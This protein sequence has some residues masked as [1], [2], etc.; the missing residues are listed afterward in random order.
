[1]ESWSDDELLGEVRSVPDAFAVFYRRYERVVFRYFMG[2]VG[3]PELAADLAA[4]TFA[5]A[6]LS[7]GRYRRRDGSASAWLFGIAR[8][9]LLRSVERKRVEDRARRKLGWPSLVLDDDLLERISQAGADGRAEAM[10]AR[11][12][13][14]Q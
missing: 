10:L 14:E 13:S 4:E 7:A 11:L 5:A 12:P 3:D 1:M 2:R 8:H 6:L 9:K